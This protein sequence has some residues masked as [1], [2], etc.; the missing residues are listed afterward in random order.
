DGCIECAGNAKA[1]ETCL[2]AVR[3]GGTVVLLGHSKLEIDTWEQLTARHVTLRGVWHF[4]LHEVPK[5]WTLYRMGLDP[6]PLV[7]HEFS[8]DQVQEAYDLFN[9][10]ATG[11]VLLRP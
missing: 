11:K 1:L 10:G 8:Y 2:S 7:T 4:H 9:R 5:L 6:T 3:V